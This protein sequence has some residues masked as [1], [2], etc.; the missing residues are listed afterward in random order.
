ML[1]IRT[2]AKVTIFAEIRTDGCGS[3]HFV[4]D[5]EHLKFGAAVNLVGGF[6]V[7]GRK[8]LNEFLGVL[9]RVFR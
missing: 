1:I 5:V 8:L 2:T 3:V 6:L 9:L 4:V 7:F